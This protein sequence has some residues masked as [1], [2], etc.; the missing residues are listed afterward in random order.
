MARRLCLLFLLVSVAARPSASQSLP[1]VHVIGTG[2][3]I[4]SAGDYWGG[5]ATRVPIEQLVQI[6]GI[7]KVASITT[8]Q[9][10]NVGSSA[11]GPDR[12]LELSRRVATVFRERPELSGIVITHGTDTMEE[13]AFFLDLTLADH[14]PVI[15]TGAMRPSSMAGADGPAN[16]F[17]A[18]RAACDPA[19]KDRG[20][21]V[22]M[23][24]RLFAAREVTKT[25]TTRVEAFQA[26]ERGPLAIVDPEGVFYH[27]PVVARRWPQFDVSGLDRL[28]RVDIVYAYAGADGAA[29]EALVA[30]GAKGLVVAGVGRG[31]TTREQREALNRAREQ[32]VVVVMGSRTGAGRVP[33]MGSDEGARRIGAGDLNAQKA[34]ILLALALTRTSDPMEIARIFEA[35]Q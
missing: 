17:N 9:L 11:I 19:G 35:N 21:M 13:T 28:P 6:P 12:W 27:R 14:R 22:L 10:W 29:V 2:G 5:N 31:G 30:A 32:G 33:V 3:T 25:N 16:L 23:D 34:R 26:P 24:D 1:A 8:E 7:E 4:G 18:V 15:V 20:V